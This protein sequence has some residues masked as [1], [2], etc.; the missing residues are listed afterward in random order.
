MQLRFLSRQRRRLAALC[1]ITLS[2]T[3]ALAAPAPALFRVELQGATDQPVSGRLLLFAAEA[4]AARAAAKGA[5]VDE[6][7]GARFATSLTS[8][9]AREVSRLAPGQSVS[10]DADELAFPDAFSKLPPGDYLM[11]AVLDVHHN[12]NYLGRGTGDLLSGVVSVHLPAATPPVITLTR[13]V[14]ADDPWA[15]PWEG[16]P[17]LLTAQVRERLPQARAHAHTIDFQSPS[18]GTFWGRPVSMRGWV[19][20]PPGYDDKAAAR[21]PTVYYAHAGTMNADRV[22]GLLAMVYAAM[23]KGAMPPM[24][25][26][27]PDDAGAGGTNEFADSANN[28]PWGRA[29]TAELI[30]HLEAEYRMDA[31]PSSRFLTGH[32]S[33]GWASLWLQTHYPKLFGGTWSTSP[34]P[35]DFHAFLSADLYAS[36]ANVYHQRDG[37]PWPMIRVGGK[38]VGDMET[39]AR[40]ERVTGS[41]GGQ[42]A[43]FEWV[44]SPRG[45][46][47]R[48]MPMFDRDTGAVDPFVLAYWHDHYDIAHYLETQWPRLKP[49]LDGK[50]HLYVG[51]ADTFYLDGSVRRM[52]GVLERLGAKAEVRFIPDKT[53][54]DL[55]A[56]G[57]DPIALL[58]DIAWQMYTL[59]RPQMGRVRTQ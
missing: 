44:F 50:I 7:G 59:A 34:D 29:F 2:S 23:A 32:S 19:L 15:K 27:F 31:R 11:Q 14:P 16:F 5:E 35:V 3:A 54:Y 56:R 38:P 20:T 48:P 46:D 26:V 39:Y 30:P 47:G 13:R 25:W 10:I 17:G 53:H 40:L 57:D 51:T 1:L 36:D 21:Y 18:L 8:V 55:Y 41:Y 9:A 52:Q 4:N 58:D 33:G 24:I 45:A 49:D 28:G 43:A 12:Y 22:I 37:S 42:F 6:V